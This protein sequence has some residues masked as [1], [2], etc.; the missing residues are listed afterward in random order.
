LDENGLTGELPA[1]ISLLTALTRISIRGVAGDPG[2]SGGIP[3]T[4][5]TLTRLSEIILQHHSFDKDIPIR[6][7][8]HW[9]SVEELNIAS[10][11]LTGSI[12]NFSSLASVKK[13]NLSG[14]HLKGS[15][16]YDLSK[17]TD[18]EIF[19]VDQNQLTGPLPAKG[20]E[21]LSAMRSFSV[22][23]NALTGAIPTQL[24]GMFKIQVLD[25]NMNMIN[26]TIPSLLDELVDLQV[27]RLSHN[28][29]SGPVP[30]FSAMTR[31]KE[32][33][34]EGNNLTGTISNATCASLTTANVISADCNSRGGGRVSCPC[35]TICCA[36]S[37]KNCSSQGF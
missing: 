25:L 31:L 34:I 33:G 24:G 17:V 26:G 2:L 15:I 30:D 22:A 23:G 21:Y 29:L 27:L 3:S 11:N 8:D 12:P 36:S 14:N 7:F 4:L 19:S 35:C 16:P 9:A 6:L 1:E 18:L 13:I 28:S 20:L 10:C 32:F 37:G 5:A